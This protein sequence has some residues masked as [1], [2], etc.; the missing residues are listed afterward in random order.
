MNKNYEGYS[1]P[2][3]F[4]AIRRVMKHKRKRKGIL[5]SKDTL[6]YRICEIPGFKKLME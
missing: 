2:T 4:E 5:K 3:A 6:T 1:D